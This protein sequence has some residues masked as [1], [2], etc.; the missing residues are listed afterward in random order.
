MMM[1]KT[2]SQSTNTTLSERKKRKLYKRIER[3]LANVRRERKNHRLHLELGDAYT[4]LEEI[5]EAD[6]HYM[7]AIDILHQDDIDEKA[8]KQII[9]LYGKILNLDPNNYDA[10]TQLGQEY[11]AAGQKEKA[12]RFLL[13]SGKKAFENG[14]Y[15]LA[16]QCYE[17]VIDL[18]K[19][20]PYIIERCTEIFL[21]LGRKNDAIENYVKIGDMY[22]REE[23]A[24]EALEY[25]KKAS[26]LDPA[27]PDL[28]LKV[29]RMYYTLEW[30]ENAAAEMVKIAEFHEQQQNFSEALKYFQHSLSL[31]REN[32]RALAGKLRITASHDLEVSG[33]AAQSEREESQEDILEELDLIEEA[34]KTQHFVQQ[35][36]EKAEVANETDAELN[37]EAPQDNSRVPEPEILPETTTSASG[38]SSSTETEERGSNVIDATDIFSNGAGTDATKEKAAETHESLEGQADDIDDFF[39]L[40]LRQT[41]KP[42]ETG[43]DAQ[44]EA[45]LEEGTAWKDRL[46]DLNLEEGFVLTTGLDDRS[47]KDVPEQAPSSSDAEFQSPQ[48][49]NTA[50]GS[51]TQR[52]EIPLPQHSEETDAEDAPKLELASE[53]QSGTEETETFEALEFPGSP[54]DAKNAE[55]PFEPAELSAPESPEEE[56]VTEPPFDTVQFEGLPETQHAEE[57]ET[58][59]SAVAPESEKN[60]NSKE[61]QRLD[62]SSDAEVASESANLDEEAEKLIAETLN[63]T[64]E[65]ASKEPESAAEETALVDSPSAE[66]AGLEA[67][68]ELAGEALQKELVA[69]SPAQETNEIDVPDF[70]GED[71]PPPTFTPVKEPEDRPRTVFQGS[72]AEL[73]IKLEDLEKQFENTE[74]EKHFLQEQFTA[75][76]GQLKSREALLKREYNRMRK[77]K[78][79]LQHRLEEMTSIYESS[80]QKA[81]EQDESRYEAI[82][83][84]IQ[85]KK[86]SLQ[87]HVNKL[88][89]QREQNGRFLAEELKS[90]G[91]TKQRLQSNL[92]YIQQVK[93]RVEQKIQTDLRQTQEE[94][95]R[96]SSQALRLE[97]E[98]D[99]KQKAEL[100]L[101]DQYDR[102]SQEKETLQDQFTETISA[103]TE[104]NEKI[105]EQLKE[106]SKEKLET[107]HLLKKKF[108]A[109][110]LSYQ[111]LR[112][113]FKSSVQSK[114]IELNRTAQRLSQ[115]ADEYVKL[116]TTLK[117]IRQERDKLERMLAQET[118]TRER[119]EDN[120]TDI[121]SQVNSLEVQGSELLGQLE[122]ELDRQFTITQSA[123]DEFQ[124][125][126]G[127]LEQLLAMQEKEIQSLEVL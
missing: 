77:D 59:M 124:G 32:D 1:I 82:V 44:Q 93:A 103:L 31:D 71:G 107:E 18:G 6:K 114:E 79:D 88:L 75:Q 100:N 76:I 53:T 39:Q 4:L 67:S 42:S 96:L 108:K 87:E 116:E 90:L 112:G 56:V 2:Y 48:E 86:Q 55:K 41:D 83:S 16:L 8:R 65:E 119:L 92:E 47:E 126:L 57:G 37:E 17:Q 51:D 102:L 27:S 73:E 94:V 118:A 98:L 110:H 104:E 10:Y 24:V 30:T 12:S 54:E 84:K 62:T 125:S 72:V 29:A 106:L 109:L 20:N 80:R 9:V 121:E 122:E 7:T 38:E 36:L 50:A 15:E 52:F 46:L 113:E 70:D 21:K 13:S 97:A 11:V 68:Q 89:K 34:L 58:E 23:K 19:S 105:G 28:T 115:F 95:Q 33:K 45:K 69:E 5:N 60:E 81:D 66:T 99:S 61:E 117:E 123:S 64:L 63:F 26:A 3:L 40:D 120:L 14:E 49:E 101:H 35:K 91:S 85:R 25:Y 22:A 78:E 43:N 74:E 111:R 127:E